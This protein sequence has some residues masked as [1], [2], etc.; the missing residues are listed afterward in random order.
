[1]GFKPPPKRQKGPQTG[2]RSVYIHL[3]W[4][5]QAGKGQKTAM[6]SSFRIGIVLLLTLAALTQGGPPAVA[7]GRNSYERVIHDIETRGFR[8]VSGLQRRGG[9]Y[10]FQAEDYFGEKVSVVMS[11]ET[12]EIIGLR[13]IP[14]R[15]N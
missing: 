6:L 3:G 10:V 9:N 7:Q 5:M 8:N 12:G 15:K 1:L 13:K 2:G 11:A 4:A 14:A